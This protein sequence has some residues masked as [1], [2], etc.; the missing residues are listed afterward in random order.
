MYKLVNSEEKSKLVHPGAVCLPVQVPT[1]D[2]EL[3]S[4][5]LTI[6]IDVPPFGSGGVEVLQ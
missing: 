2:S 1:Q 6:T 5:L 4:S 3:G